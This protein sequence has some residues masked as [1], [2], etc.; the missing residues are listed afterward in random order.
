[1][2]D[3]LEIN[4]IYNATSPNGFNNN[5]N[6]NVLNNYNRVIHLYNISALL[7]INIAV[8]VTVLILNPHLTDSKD[9]S[10]SMV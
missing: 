6:N 1:M 3:Y 7:H 2:K 4:S 8:E 5:N 10:Q 9:H